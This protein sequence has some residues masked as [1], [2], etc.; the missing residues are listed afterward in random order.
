MAERLTIK[1]FESQT[2]S[3]NK[4]S[5]IEFYSDTCVPCKRLS[6][7]LAELEEGYPDDIYVGKVNVAYEAELVEKYDVRSTPTL[8]FMKN[9]EVLKQLV[10]IQKKADLEEYIKEWK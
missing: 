6:V 4:L 10:G 8:V 3:N 1:N 2:F 7:I 5:L 9:G